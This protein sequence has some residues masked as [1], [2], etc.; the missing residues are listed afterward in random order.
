MGPI[1]RLVPGQS[2]DWHGK[3]KFEEGPEQRWRDC[4]VVDVSSAGAGLEV[5]R[6][7]RVEIAGTRILLAVHL[8]AELCY[9][10]PAQ[11]NT[12]A[13][14]SMLIRGQGRRWLGCAWIAGRDA[15][16]RGE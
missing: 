15:S 6:T 14:R 8:C 11:D 10:A 9:T 2:T 13:G 16:Q 3:F 5:L 7:T 1:R 4:R 12:G